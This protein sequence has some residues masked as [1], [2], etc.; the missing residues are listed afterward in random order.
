MLKAA[1]AGL[2]AL[3]LSLSSLSVSAQDMGERLR[4]GAQ[5]G[6]M[7]TNA[8]IA[9]FKAKLNLTPAQQQF[10]PAIDAAL[11]DIARQQAAYAA[12]SGAPQRMNRNV[13]AIALTTA[14]VE[15]LTAAAQPLVRSLDDGQKLDAMRMAHE[16][17]LA[18]MMSALN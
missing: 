18:S 7:L 6:V 9:Y 12:A 15:R 5:S 4:P 14:A 2:V 17:G 8:H 3:T 1:F 11:R 10:W 13:L 16:V